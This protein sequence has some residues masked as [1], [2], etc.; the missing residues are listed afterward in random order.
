MKCSASSWAMG[1][2]CRNFYA[3][4]LEAEDT[5]HENTKRGN[6]R[7][8][9]AGRDQLK[10]TILHHRN[11]VRYPVRCRSSVR[12]VGF[13]LRSAW[14]PPSTGRQ[15]RRLP[16]TKTTSTTTHIAMM[17]LED[18]IGTTHIMVSQ[19]VTFDEHFKSALATTPTHTSAPSKAP[20]NS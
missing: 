19:D 2:T 10:T 20:N 4:M 12:E 11:C 14:Q 16:T 7:V 6:L 5:P 8:I 18:R 1:S 17:C 9:A 13:L 3:S 15:H